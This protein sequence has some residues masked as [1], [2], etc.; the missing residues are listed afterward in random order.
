MVF[1]C[2]FLTMY[3]FTVNAEHTYFLPIGI[4]NFNTMFNGYDMNLTIG[5]DCVDSD[6]KSVV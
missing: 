2:D 5:V 1:T 3:Q 6:R 4:V